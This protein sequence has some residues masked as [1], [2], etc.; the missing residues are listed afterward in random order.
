MKGLLFL[1]LLSCTLILTSAAPP[2]IL[3]NDYSKRFVKDECFLT[4]SERN[5]EKQAFI[6]GLPQTTIIESE[7]NYTY[8]LEGE[9]LQFCYRVVY[10]QGASENIIKSTKA[11][12]EETKCFDDPDVRR[13]KKWERLDA[14]PQTVLIESWQEHTNYLGGPLIEYCYTIVWYD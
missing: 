2:P 5:Q 11:R 9:I 14:L 12:Y 3:E 8:Y 1:L 13:A 10:H 6:V 4:A 7:E